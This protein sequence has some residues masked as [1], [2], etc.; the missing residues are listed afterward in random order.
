MCRCS[1][2]VCHKG[3]FVLVLFN[4]HLLKLS[5]VYY[6]EFN[7]VGQTIPNHLH[8]YR[9][10]SLHG[11]SVGH[12]T[13]NWARTWLCIISGWAAVYKSQTISSDISYNC[14][15]WKS[16]ST[17]HKNCLSKVN[18]EQFLFNICLYCVHVSSL[19]ASLILFYSFYRVCYSHTQ[20]SLSLLESVCR[21][22][23]MSEP[24][25]LV[26]ETG[27]GKTATVNYLADITGY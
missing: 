25:L 11:V 18:I 2:S 20:S 15:C 26:G 22:V 7:K 10:P 6:T 3:T 9:F 8:V 19:S 1:Y 14:S 5:Q 17:L 21:C 12:C 24:V 13:A 23:Q 4:M 27:V 16:I